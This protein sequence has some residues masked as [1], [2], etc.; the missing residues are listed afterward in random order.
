MVDEQ[1][2]I[3]DPTEREAFENDFAIA[4]AKDIDTLTK[5]K[6]QVKYNPEA[7]LCSTC[8]K[9]I[10]LN[11][12]GRLRVHNVGKAGSERCESSNNYPSLSEHIAK[13]IEEFFK[14]HFA[15]QQQPD[16]Q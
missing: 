3:P 15:N 1:P 12:N 8:K 13:P 16:A 10:R 11:N 2:W 14:N 5:P 4:L 9:R 7:V 6:R